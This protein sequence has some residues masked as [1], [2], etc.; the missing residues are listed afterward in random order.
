MDGVWG[1]HRNGDVSGTSRLRAAPA[2]EPSYSCSSVHSKS[3]SAGASRRR[4]RFG[5][6]G[7]CAMNSVYENSG[8]GGAGVPSQQSSV[9]I[10]TDVASTIAGSGTC[11]PSSTSNPSASAATRRAWAKT[12]STEPAS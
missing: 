1:D 11:Q 5:A 9:P 12:G 7:S 2:S 4:G 8:G 10:A 3:E 6:S